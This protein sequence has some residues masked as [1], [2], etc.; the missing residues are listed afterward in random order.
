MGTRARVPKGYTGT[1][2]YVSYRQVVVLPLPPA[3]SL[4][5]HPGGLGYNGYTGTGTALSVGTSSCHNIQLSDWCTLNDRG[6]ITIHG[7]TLFEPMKENLSNEVWLA[8]IFF[9]VT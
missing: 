4:T 7:K 8:S 2:P 5:T 6:N 3:Y 1:G 9:H